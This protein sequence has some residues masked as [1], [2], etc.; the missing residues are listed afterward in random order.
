MIQKVADRKSK[1][2][3]LV[4]F[5]S[6][7][8]Q[9]IEFLDALKTGVDKIDKQHEALVG[10]INFLIESQGESSPPETIS[11]ILGEMSKYV[12]LHFRDEEQFMLDNFYPGLAE[13]QKI[14]QSFEDK[15]RELQGLYDAGRTDLLD[16]VL[17][18]LTN[19]LVNHIQG[20]DK[21]MVDE[22]FANRG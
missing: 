8:V 21:D 17:E 6:E 13:H 5:W 10:M 19:W 3:E 18:Y 4:L 9:T 12:Y 22:V 11:F 20:D 1:R 16:D 2:G 15:I 7:I 14:H